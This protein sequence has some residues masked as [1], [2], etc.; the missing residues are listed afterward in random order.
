MNSPEAFA[1][2]ACLLKAIDATAKGLRKEKK[3]TLDSDYIQHAILN[4]ELSMLRKAR[5]EIAG[6]ANPYARIK[7]LGAELKKY[8]DEQSRSKTQ[9]SSS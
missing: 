3:A 2:S 4:A 1:I 6:V 9:A 5:K 8:Q 7:A